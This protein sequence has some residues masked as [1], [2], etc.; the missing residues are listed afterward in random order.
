MTEGVGQDKLPA[1]G[2]SPHVL[3][4]SKRVQAI[5][6]QPPHPGPCSCVQPAPRGRDKR[7]ALKDKASSSS[8]R[9]FLLFDASS[10]QQPRAVSTSLPACPPLL[11]AGPSCQKGSSH[12]TSAHFCS[13]SFSAKRKTIRCQVASRKHPRSC[14]F[15]HQFL[16][17]NL[18]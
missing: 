10:M 18:K 6:K 7:R 16:P 4:H 3:P 9:M 15:Q 13:G 1:L 12:M 11:W 17:N 8:E 2:T 14:L 5:C